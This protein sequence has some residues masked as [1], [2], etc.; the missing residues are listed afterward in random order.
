MVAAAGIVDAAAA[1][2]A[3][4]T[5]AAVMLAVVAVMLA[6]VADI[7]LADTAAAGD[8]RSEPSFDLN[9]QLDASIL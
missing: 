6:V 9:D 8:D 3:A 5:A 1:D 7:W 2:V 4:F